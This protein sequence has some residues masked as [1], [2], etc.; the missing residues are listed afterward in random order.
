[1][2]ISIAM[3]V[4]V[5]CR[6]ELSRG[7]FGNAGWREE[8]FISRRWK[9]SSPSRRRHSGLVRSRRQV[10]TGFCANDFG[11]AFAKRRERRYEHPKPPSPPRVAQPKSKG[12]EQEPKADKHLCYS[13]GQT[14]RAAALKVVPAT[15]P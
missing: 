7:L 14:G 11:D 12:Y 8:D 15:F 3:S 4:R 10:R 2:R 9:L 6:V 1:M 5:P 13:V